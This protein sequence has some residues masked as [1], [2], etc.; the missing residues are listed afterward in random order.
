MP[1]SRWYSSSARSPI[2]G[3][4]GYNGFHASLSAPEER[5]AWDS[6]ASHDGMGPVAQVTVT[7]TVTEGKESLPVRQ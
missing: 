7:V 5:E 2:A 4:C 6:H 3:V 1:L